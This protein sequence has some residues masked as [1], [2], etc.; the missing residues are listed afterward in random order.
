VL[1]DEKTLAVLH[2]A[3][4][5]E[6]IAGSSSLLELAATPAAIRSAFGDIAVAV[7]SALGKVS[8]SVLGIELIALPA[9]IG[10]AEGVTI[11]FA[12]LFFRRARISIA[13]PTSLSLEEEELDEED[14]ELFFLFLTITDF[15]SALPVSESLD[16][17][18]DE[19]EEEE[20]E[21]EEDPFF[22]FAFTLID[23]TSA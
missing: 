22:F 21:D 2:S 7:A 23:S 16:S 19:L 10:C 17:D 1:A 14:D 6:T 15:M 13:F 12:K 9:V 11:C 5:C 3:L 20:E 4:I 18:D 8:T